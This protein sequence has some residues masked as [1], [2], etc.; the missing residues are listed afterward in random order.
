M[1]ANS[2]S[3]D[4]RCRASIMRTVPLRERKS[5][6]PALV[7]YFIEKK[8]GELKVGEAPRLATGAIERHMVFANND[9]PGVMLAGAALKYARVWG[10]LPGKR[11]VLCTNN[12]SAYAT[13]LDL[14]AAGVE[15]RSI[16]DVTPIPHNGCRPPKRRRV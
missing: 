2:R 10:V 12:D 4:T 6:I 13:A 5:D 16:R 15:I 3:F 7:Q 1:A 9:R 8:A 14:Q 11:I